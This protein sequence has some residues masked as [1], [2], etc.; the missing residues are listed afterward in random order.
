MR[1]LIATF[2]SLGDLFPYLNI[3][4][5]LTESGHTVTFATNE[6]HRERVE[7][8]GYAFRPL[9]PHLAFDPESFNRV[10][11]E[12]D[13][14]RY[15]LRELMF[16]AIRDSYEDLKNALPSHDVVVSHVLTFAAPLLARQS[17]VPWVSSI[18][19]PLSFFSRTDPPLVS[20]PI[21]RL[22]PKILNLINR[23]AQRSTKDWSGPYHQLR[24]ELGQISTGNPLFEGQHS[25]TSVLAL[26]SKHFAA[27][28]PDWPKQT[29]LT[30]F[31]LAPPAA[32]PPEIERFLAAGPP[33]IVFTLGSSAVALPGKFF[34]A[35]RALGMRAILLTGE[36]SIPASPDVLAVDY[37]PHSAV[38]PHAAAIV[39]QA[40]IGTASE[41]LRSG[42][43]SLAVPFAFDQPDNAARMERFGVARI[44]SRRAVKPANLRRELKVLLENPNYAEAAK[45]LA[46]NIR[47]EDGARTAASVLE[48]LNTD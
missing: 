20:L 36:N 17:G 34:E 23:A 32:L 27:P 35:A 31:P 13:G 22:P 48:K 1:I 40:G 14:G 10:F 2:G 30:G 12:F 45:R 19:A 15:L 39:H 18:L 6:R 24:E 16:P 41:V 4:K 11:S 29:T 42:R 28:Q 5:H 3:A 7:A 26:F 47:S 21:K 9:R 33:P 43:P 8:A 46:G 25:P 38:F 44:L 37:A